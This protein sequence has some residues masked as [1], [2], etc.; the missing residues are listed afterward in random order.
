MPPPK[1]LVAGWVVAVPNRPPG[2][3]W[4][5]FVA[6]DQHDKLTERLHIES[7]PT[8]G[9]EA[10]RLLLLLLWLLTKQ[11]CSCR[12]LLLLLLAKCA[13]RP[14]AETSGRIRS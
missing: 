14:G 7:E 8:K 6:P 2:F 10:G 11:P 13:R 5:L 4:L 9:A 12:R 3:A 1:A